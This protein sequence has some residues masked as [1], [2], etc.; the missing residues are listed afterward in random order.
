MTERRRNLGAGG[1]GL[2][3]VYLRSRGYR[4]IET[5]YT[6]P[7]GEIDLIAQKDD[8]III[9]EVKTRVNAERG[10]PFEAITPRKQKRLR[11]LAEHYWS[12]TA[13]QK[14]ALRFD[15]IAV[16]ETPTGIKIEH[17]EDAF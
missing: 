11:K 9:C 8:V 10:H 3:A 2:A 4:V 5:N 1:E 17:V 14:L 16:Y 13:D 12:F 15:A 7:L 6:C